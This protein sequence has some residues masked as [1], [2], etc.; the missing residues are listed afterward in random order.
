M[1]AIRVST[2]TSYKLMCADYVDS[3]DLLDFRAE[4]VKET[5]S[6]RFSLLELLCRL[7]LD[8]LRAVLPCHSE[9]AADG[10]SG[11]CLWFLK[12]EF[13]IRFTV[14]VRRPTYLPL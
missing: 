11:F 2:P 12:P 4:E 10:L 6:R 13:D 3:T 5:V 7:V 1:L 8:L 9:S 14:L